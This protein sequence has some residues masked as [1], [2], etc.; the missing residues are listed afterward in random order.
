V[1]GSVAAGF[2]VGFAVDQILIGTLVGL[3]VGA[4][5]A[6]LVIARSSRRREA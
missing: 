4:G 3:F 5:L 1:T 6:M 2:S